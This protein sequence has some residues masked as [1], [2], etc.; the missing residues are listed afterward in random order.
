MLYIWKHRKQERLGQERK[1]LDLCSP[2][3]CARHPPSAGAGGTGAALPFIMVMGP[4]SSLA[5]HGG[6]AAPARFNLPRRG[7]S[8]LF[9]FF[10][11]GGSDRGHAVGRGVRSTETSSSSPCGGWME[12]RTE[13]EPPLPC[14]G[15]GSISRLWPGWIGPPKGKGAGLGQV[16]HCGCC[17]SRQP[18]VGRML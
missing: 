13:P 18:E 16:G 10:C 5:Q 1:R 15:M 11:Q 8:W 7:F 14:T 17:W 9:L 2:P 12:G 6:H 3:L 4:A